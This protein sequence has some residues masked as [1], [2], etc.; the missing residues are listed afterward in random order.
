MFVSSELALQKTSNLKS[1]IAVNMCLAVSISSVFKKRK[2]EIGVHK[3][4]RNAKIKIQP[5]VNR[6]AFH[7][8]YD[9]TS[10][11]LLPY[12]II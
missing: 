5:T 9:L 8:G 11:L 7:I 12:Y 1:L 6:L 3:G 4:K 2:T 10:T